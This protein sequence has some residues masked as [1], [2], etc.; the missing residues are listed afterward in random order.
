MRAA[1]RGFVALT[2]ATCLVG[3]YLAV[4]MAANAAGTAPVPFGA[5]VFNGYGTGTELQLGALTFGGM[6]VA[7]VGQGLSSAS[8]NS[9]GLATAIN[10]ES[11]NAVNPADPGFK[12]YGSGSGLDLG[13]ATTAAQEQALLAGKATAMAP[14]PS[15]PPPKLIGPINLAPIATAQALRGDASAVYDPAGQTCPLG[16]PIAS[17]RGDAA[18]VQ[19]ASVL[20]NGV[21]IVNTA[22]AAGGTTTANSTSKTFLSSNGDGTFGLTSQSSEIIAPVTVNLLGIAT[23]QLTVAGST[24]N[25][26]VALNAVTTGNASGASVSLA[27]NDVINVALGIGAATPTPLPGF[28]IAVSQ[29]GPSGVHINLDT[30]TLGNAAT[31]LLGAL[32]GAVQN[33]PALGMALMNLVGPTS[34]LGMTIAGILNGAGGAISGV[35]NLSLGSLDLDA[36]PHAINGSATSAATVVGGTLASGAVD[37]VHLNLG[38]SGTIAGATIPALGIANLFVG[39]LETKAALNA[40]ILCTIKVLKTATPSTVQAGN[41]FEYDIFVPDPATIPEL[42][43]SLANVNVVDTISDDPGQGNPTFQV[44]STNDG[45]KV[46]QSSATNATVTWTGLTYTLGGP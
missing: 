26:P 13:L 9:T 23:L 16:Q 33:V 15:S 35:A 32:T 31:G 41:N 20:P 11:G 43:C 25:S 45:G 18:N 12:A 46:N 4:P 2:G 40:P 3:S 1:L 8:T 10:S 28:P 21:P 17:G 22:G 5:A 7:Q 29:L 37:L 36:T 38:L 34:P 42:A 19:A 14:P 30:A 27:S 6:S 24:P 44:V 39:H